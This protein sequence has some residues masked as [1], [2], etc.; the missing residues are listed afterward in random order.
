[1]TS[2]KGWRRDKRFEISDVNLLPVSSLQDELQ[3]KRKMHSSPEKKEWMRGKCLKPTLVTSSE[4]FSQRKK[5][6]FRE[7]LDFFHSLMFK[8]GQQKK[9]DQQL[10]GE[11]S[12][13]I[14]TKLVFT[15]K[16]LKPVDLILEQHT[17]DRTN[18]VSAFCIYSCFS[19]LIYF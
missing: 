3:R 10:K 13:E 1:M 4:C 8:T 9:V 5:N 15:V 11:T 6:W 2:Y 18:W 16:M 7:H 14:L 19:L 17:F 12:S